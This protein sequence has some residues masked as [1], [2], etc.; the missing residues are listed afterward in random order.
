MLTLAIAVAGIIFSTLLGTTL[1][2]LR[3]SRTRFLHL[4]AA[5]YV[6]ALRNLPLLVLVFWAYFAPPYFGM[7]LS[8]TASVTIAII[9]FNSAY[10]AEIFR[11]GIRTVGAGQLQAAQALGLGM[12]DV[13]GWVIM[14]QAFRNMIPA[15]TGRYVTIV[16]GTSLAFL[17][18]SLVSC[19]GSSFAKSLD[20]V[21]DGIR[22]RRPDKG[23]AV[24]VV[25]RHVVVDRRFE[26][27]NV[28]K[29]ASSNALGRD[30][31]KEPLDLIQ[32]TGTGRREV[33]VIPRM[34]RKPPPDLRHFVGPV[35]VH[36]DVD[37]PRRGSA[38][39]RRFR[40]LSSLLVAMPEHLRDSA[41]HNV[42]KHRA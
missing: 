16:K 39:S 41:F 26:R 9:L 13:L 42:H 33:Q 14:P 19:L 17:V 35:V 38:A 7:R 20:L 24:L 11:A 4:P 32:P 30:P 28:F 23:L 2:L 22:C 8:K 12:F 29:G 27:P 6:G 3:S 10:L 37:L 34:P 21:E 5:F 36:D 31:R 40:N 15:I 18:Y 25:M 1:A